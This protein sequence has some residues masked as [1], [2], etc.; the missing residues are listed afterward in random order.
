MGYDGKYGKVTTEYGD[1]PDGEP[2]LVFR[3]RDKNT[4]ALIAFYHDLCKAGGSPERH[5][6]L[7]RDAAQRFADWQDQ[8]P[9]Q[10]KVPDSERSRAWMDGT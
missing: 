10:V 8:H 3:A 1:I 7:V 6:T 2:V 5:L 4:P 9:D